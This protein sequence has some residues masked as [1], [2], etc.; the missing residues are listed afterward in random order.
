MTLMTPPNASDPYSDESGPFTTSTR[1]TPAS[2][3]RLRSR[4]S[5]SAPPAGCPSTST[6]TR[7]SP[8]PRIAIVEPMGVPATACNPGI[9]CSRLPAEAAP[10]AAISPASTRRTGSATSDRGWTRPDAV[11]TTSARSSGSASS[12][13]S[14]LASARSMA[15][16]RYPI[17]RIR[18][19]PCCHATGTRKEPSPAVSRPPA[20][21]SPE[22]GIHDTWAPAMG[23][24]DSRSV[25][26]ATSCAAARVVAT[27]AS[28]RATTA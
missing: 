15:T 27:A 23:R 16:A 12:G 5:I 3:S 17:A 4:F 14:P 13:T 25:T 18:R 2:D 11:T 9:S 22:S 19:R 28:T 6:R 10:D 24:P 7:A 8:I 20:G 21:A 1:S 26:R